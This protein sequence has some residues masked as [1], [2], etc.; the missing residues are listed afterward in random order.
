MATPVDALRTEEAATTGDSGSSDA[1]P[2]ELIH[3]LVAT[4]SMPKGK[5]ATA[6]ALTD[7]QDKARRR[8]WERRSRE[9]RKANIETMKHQV[10]AL[11]CAVANVM[12]VREKV[13]EWEELLDED[14]VRMRQFLQASAELNEELAKEQ[15]EKVELRRLLREYELSVSAIR[16][17]MRNEG[18]D[19]W[20][21][22]VT[23][24]R[25]ITHANFT[26][27]T[28]GQ[29]QEVI[30]QAMQRIQTFE[31]RDDLVSSGM[32]FYGWRDRRRLDE[33][34]N[35]VEFSFY[36]DYHGHDAEDVADRY[37]QLHLKSEEYGRIM[38]G[39]NVKVYY[40][41]L[42]EVTPDICIIRCAEEYPGIPVK[43]HMVSIIFR[44]RTD[45]SYLQVVKTIPADEIQ[46]AT[47][48]VDSF[49]STNFH[50]TKFDVLE[51]DPTGRCVAYRATLTGSLASES[52]HY[53]HHW[54]FATMATLVR[55]E[56]MLL[57][58]KLLVF[59]CTTR[60]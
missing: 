35:K 53:V 32:H 44:L 25:S 31:L 27:W 18:G 28:L 13:D 23:R 22:N 8:L 24:W 59:Q 3:S 50:W 58:R 54:M 21:W 41:V 15:A 20:S 4:H 39:P 33:Q 10:K 38:L 56:T 9:R 40:E 6:K 14:S 19:D 1:E 12:F 51:R 7:E 45:T 43:I 52:A 55:A 16:L 17:L 11:E 57:G 46:A 36:K 42:Q 5:S 29:C 34:S 30:D 26:P 2:V 48:D 37:W 49:W 47:N 60:S